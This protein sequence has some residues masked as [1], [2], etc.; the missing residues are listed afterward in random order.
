MDRSVDKELVGW[1]QPKGSDQRLNVWMETS[2][3]RSPSGVRTGTGAVQYYL[4]MTWT[5]TSSVPSASLQM[6][7]S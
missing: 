6:T 7:P 3:E 2:D 4:S 5:A 1:S